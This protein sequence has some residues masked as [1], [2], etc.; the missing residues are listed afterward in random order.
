MH[1]HIWNETDS[2]KTW[3]NQSDEIMSNYAIEIYNPK[4]ETGKR[5]NIHNH[6]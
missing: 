2:T 5:T 3:K 1:V 4:Y 6:L